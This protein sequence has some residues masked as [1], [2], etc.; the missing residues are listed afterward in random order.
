MRDAGERLIDLGWHKFPLDTQLKH[1][2][3]LD[4]GVVHTGDAKFL[5]RSAL[6]LG[7]DVSVHDRSTHRH[8]RRGLKIFY[9]YFKIEVKFSQCRFDNTELRGGFPGYWVSVVGEGVLDHGVDQIS[10]N[11]FVL[12]HDG[13]R[14]ILSEQL[15]APSKVSLLG[16][17][18]T[19]LP[20]V[21]SL[22]GV[23]VNAIP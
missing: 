23:R 15:G 6:R 21:S 5:F 14:D 19:P 1:L 12:G 13:G 20:V 3:D 2:P 10:D 11:G 16:S 17:C 4:D 22:T 7:H 18:E 8:Q 9:F